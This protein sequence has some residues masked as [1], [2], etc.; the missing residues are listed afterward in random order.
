MAAQACRK[1]AIF[2]K[3]QWSQVHFMRSTGT[4]SRGALP[5]EEFVVTPVIRDWAYAI[6]GAC[7][8]NWIAIV[9]HWLSVWRGVLPC[10][11]TIPDVVCGGWLECFLTVC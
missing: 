10:S 11:N 7:R 5:T 6:E 9:N 3:L 8:A 4:D 1:V 2:L